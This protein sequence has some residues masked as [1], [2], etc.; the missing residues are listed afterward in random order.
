MKSDPLISI[1]LTLFNSEKTVEAVLNGISTQDFPLDKIELI[2]VDGGSKDRTLE[3]V[4]KFLLENS[5]RFHSTKLIIHD[6]N[7]GLSKARND[8]IRVSKGRY[9][10][11]LDHDVILL[12]D[13]LRKSLE[14]IESS[15]KRVAAVIP[16]HRNLCSNFLMRWEYRIRKGKV[17]RATAITSCALLRRDLVNEIGFYD[18]TLGPPLTPICED[19]YGARALARGYE[20]HVVGFIE[21]LHDICEEPRENTVIS[22]RNYIAFIGSVVEALKSLGDSRYRYTYKRYLRSSPRSVKLRW[23]TY[24]ALMLSAVPLLTVSLLSRSLLPLSIWIL[25]TTLAY[26]DVLRYYWN[27]SLP[28][29]S[30]AYS[31][32]AFAW[33][34]FRSVMLLI[35][36]PR[37]RS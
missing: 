34:L 31:A 23:V 16:L 15:H 14:Y 36:G 10:L 3:I 1:V 32:I 17:T 21:V 6:R 27:S 4:D 5:H 2:I 22:Q 29:V 26:L 20:I 12:G 25:L 28:H 11:I 33:R 7:Y 19:E 35:P 18:E 9:L 30:I 8:G 13:T 37:E 24:L